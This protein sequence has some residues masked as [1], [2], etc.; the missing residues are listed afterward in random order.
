MDGM[1]KAPF[2]EKNMEQII[3][4]LFHLVKKASFCDIVRGR[5]KGGFDAFFDS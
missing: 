3:A 4:R 1:T 2:F 5:D